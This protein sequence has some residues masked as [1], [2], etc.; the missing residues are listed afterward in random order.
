MEQKKFSKGEL[1]CKEGTDGDEMYLILSGK[2]RPFKTLNARTIELS[3]IE[4]DD[5]FGEMSLFS[6]STRTASIAAIEDTEVLV[7]NK[8]DILNKINEDP[9]F[10]IKMI[11]TL[12]TR[13]RNTHELIV[14]LEGVKKSFEIMYK[15]K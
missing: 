6:E 8:D 5:F 9:Q 10:G 13:L 1:I 2:V 14:S 15:K 11:T 7:L 3:N 12:V 4:K